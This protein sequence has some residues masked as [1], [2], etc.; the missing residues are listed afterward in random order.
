MNRYR[1]NEI[2]QYIKENPQ[3][4]NQTIWTNLSNRGRTKKEYEK[5]INCG[6][7]GCL[8]GHGSFRYAPA[9]TIFYT[10]TL[11]VPNRELMKYSTYGKEAFDLNS[12]EVCYLFDV[13][14]TIEDIDSFV[15]DSEFYNDIKDEHQSAC[16]CAVYR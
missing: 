8:A 14:R 6:T 16:G 15:N 1:L 11:Q 5:T 3:T 10:K 7:T 4:H 12:F 2:I 13:D 9:D